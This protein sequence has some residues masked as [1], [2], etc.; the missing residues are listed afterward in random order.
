MQPLHDPHAQL[1][2]GNAGAQVTHTFVGGRCVYANGDWKT[3]DIA[4]T[5][6]RAAAW[7]ERMHSP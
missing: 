2:H 7:R 1:I 4:E 6:A 5:L 3:L